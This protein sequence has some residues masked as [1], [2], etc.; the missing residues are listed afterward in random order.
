MKGRPKGRRGIQNMEHGQEAP[1]PG[2][3]GESL[4]GQPKGPRQ[5]MAGAA[6]K[7]ALP[8]KVRRGSG[9]NYAGS[10]GG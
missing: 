3:P 5:K 10:S 4:Y 8:T 9:A 1:S 2:H 7:A 6:K